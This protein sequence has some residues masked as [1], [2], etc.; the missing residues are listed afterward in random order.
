[1]KLNVNKTVKEAVKG[2]IMNNAK[3]VKSCDFTTNCPK[4]QAGKQCKYCYVEAKRDMG[5]NAKKVIDTLVY[6]GEILKMKKDMIS[7]LNSIG[8]IRL[9]SFGDYMEEQNG[10]ITQFLLDCRQM[11]LFVKVV[12]KVVGFLDKF[13]SEF[14]DVF[15][16]IH[17]S[18]DN[19]G[20]G[21]DWEL[22]MNYRNK[23]GKSNN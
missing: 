9:F 15:S 3:T 21:I 18:V 8:G 14:E 16:I 13:Y 6:N 17:L 11:G 23:I 20:D 12:T 5:F 19:I 7:K 10:Y 4:R 22:A 2:C 1:M